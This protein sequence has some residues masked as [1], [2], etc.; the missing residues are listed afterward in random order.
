MYIIIEMKRNVDI[1]YNNIVG[2]EYTRYT[3]MASR[4]AH[5]GLHAAMVIMN[6]NVRL[7]E[8]KKNGVG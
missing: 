5:C 8:K 7:R 1:N 4:V 2:R 3:C 6:A